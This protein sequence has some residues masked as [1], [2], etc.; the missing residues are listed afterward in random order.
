M[1]PLRK[2]EG[3][4]SQANGYIGAASCP[5]SSLRGGKLLSIGSPYSFA[6]HMLGAGRASGWGHVRGADER[7]AVCDSPREADLVPSRMKRLR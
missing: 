1:N 7:R 2:Y 4:V 5:G 3:K 6:T